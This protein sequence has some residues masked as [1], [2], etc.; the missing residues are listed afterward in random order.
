MKGV[1]S[2]RMRTLLSLLQKSSENQDQWNLTIH[3][4]VGFTCC[5]CWAT[6]LQRRSGKITP[7][8]SVIFT[9][10]HFLQELKFAASYSGEITCWKRDQVLGAIY[11]IMTG[12]DRLDAVEHRRPKLKKIADILLWLSIFRFAYFFTHFRTCVF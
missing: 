4:Y 12:A 11:V 7:N 5:L 1:H 9:V 3:K 8:S 2:L 6:S 10:F